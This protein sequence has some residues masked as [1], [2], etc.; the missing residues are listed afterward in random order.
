MS[1]PLPCDIIWVTDFIDPRC[2]P[3]VD[4]LADIDCAPGIP[5]PKVG[6]VAS[7][8]G[9]IP[10]NSVK[11]CASAAPTREWLD[12]TLN[13]RIAAGTSAL[14]NIIVHIFQNPTGHSCSDETFF[15]ECAASTTLLIN[16]IP[17]G[18]TFTLSGEERKVIMSAGT[19]AKNASSNVTDITGQPF[20]WPDLACAPACVCVTFDCNNT[21]VD[22]TVNVTR[23]DREL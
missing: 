15:P 4:I 2:P 3:P 8:C 7:G 10:M 17:A 11:I 14:R 12:S 1:P 19:V 13:I 18:A 5:V 6:L 23:I 22:A 16:F 21:S 20:T 9:C